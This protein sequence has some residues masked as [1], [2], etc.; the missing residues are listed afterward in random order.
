MENA[1]ECFFIFMIGAIF[2]GLIMNAI[3]FFNE[4]EFTTL[5]GGRFVRVDA[6][7]EDN[8]H[9]WERCYDL[10]VSEI[11]W[12]ALKDYEAFLDEFDIEHKC[13][14]NYGICEYQCNCFVEDV[15]RRC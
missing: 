8:I 13:N 11:R 1:F 2:T 14:F 6:E 3:L 5:F 9:N 4:D 10:K 12:N 7:Q 15:W